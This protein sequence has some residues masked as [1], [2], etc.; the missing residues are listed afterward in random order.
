MTDREAEALVPVARV[1][2]GEINPG[3][4]RALQ[5]AAVVCRAETGVLTLTGPGAVTCFQGLLTNDVD[6]PGDGS[7]VYGARPTPKGRIVAD[8][9]AERIDTTV[10][11]TVHADAR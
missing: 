10:T 2:P 8:G 1:E 6:V 3:L 7:F 4:V 11:C 9:R 5:T